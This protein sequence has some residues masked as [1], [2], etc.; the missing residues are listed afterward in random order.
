M[1][2]VRSGRSAAVCSP[3]F[4]ELDVIAN[5]R[6]GVV[7]VIFSAE[8]DGHVAVVCGF[9]FWAVVAGVAHPIVEGFAQAGERVFVLG[10]SGEVLG[11]PRVADPV[12]EFF[13]GAFGCKKQV[14]LE[15]G[16]FSFCMQLFQA[17]KDGFSV[18]VGV[19]L[20]ER[21][22][23]VEV[24]DVEELLGAD[25]S[26]S[27]NGFITTIA[28]GKHVGARLIGG[29][30]HI[31]TLHGFWD[32]DLSCGQ[33][34]CCHIDMLDEVGA[35]GVGGDVRAGDDEGNVGAL[36]V[37]ELFAAGVADAVVGHED[38]ERVLFQALVLEPF[39]DGSD[40]V[41]CEANGIEVG[42]PIGE[43]EGFSRV[44][45]GE[46]E[47][48]GVECRAEEFFGALVEVARCVGA[49]FTK[50]AS[51]ELDL[52]EEGLIGFAKGP[53]C[54]VVERS[55]PIEVVI[56]FSEGRTSFAEGG[57]CMVEPDETASDAGVVAGFFEKIW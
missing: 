30:E 16:E 27:F 24:P 13:G 28:C 53:I 56:G 50:L 11:L 40:V 43:D 15:F 9:G 26:E 31:L 46:D 29:G 51:V 45:G 1:D 22:F 33:R 19:G 54:V 3:T 57:S 20:E 7:C 18:L 41:I 6:G 49:S 44:I 21:T 47:L 42:V 36:V 23:R 37:E 4:H 2:T 52:H 35:L 39:E 34:E 5:W 55:F 12:V 10:R 48:V 14:I 8:I 17:L 38:D 25:A 32:G